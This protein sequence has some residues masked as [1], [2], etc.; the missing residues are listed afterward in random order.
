MN[1]SHIM[2]LVDKY[3]TPTKHHP[4]FWH[5]PCNTPFRAALLV[6][7]MYIGVLLAAVLV[8]CK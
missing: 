1:L 4:S 3:G 5:N 7:T 8:T 2:R 6:A